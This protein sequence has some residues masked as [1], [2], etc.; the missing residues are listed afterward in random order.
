MLLFLHTL[1]RGC[2]F[3]WFFQIFC[4]IKQYSNLAARKADGF[5][6]DEKKN[7]NKFGN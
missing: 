2:V 3:F 4:Y 1:E 5:A 7:E 6:S